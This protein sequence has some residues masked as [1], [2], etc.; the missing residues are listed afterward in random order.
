M[1]SSAVLAL[2][3]RAITG[4]EPTSPLDSLADS[5]ALLRAVE[6]HHQQAIIAAR[7][8]GS[9]WQA[10][11]D[12]MGVSIQAARQAHQRAQARSAHRIR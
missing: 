8:A 11:G 12:V 2:A 10:I 5:L 4:R 7:D 9:T 6:Q 1:D 3:E